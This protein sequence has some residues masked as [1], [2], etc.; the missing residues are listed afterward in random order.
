[1]QIVDVFMEMNM[2]QQCTAFLSDPKN[3]RPTEGHLQTRLLEMTAP[4]VMIMTCMHNIEGFIVL[5]WH[6]VKAMQVFN[7]NENLTYVM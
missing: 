6:K 4:E 5:F 3:N 1:M 2:G 7:Y